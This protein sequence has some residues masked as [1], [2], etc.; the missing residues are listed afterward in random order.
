M[1]SAVGNE[2]APQRVPGS[3]GENANES[4]VGGRQQSLGLRVRGGGY[5]DICTDS[6]AA[7]S[8]PA[9]RGADPRIDELRTVGLPRIW[10]TVAQEIGFEAF[11]R[12]WHVMMRYGHVDDRSRVV[13]PNFSRYTRFQRNQLVRNL[14]ME[15]LDVDE[16]REAVNR[17]T[18][19]MISE[20][21]IRRFATRPK[22]GA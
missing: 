22:I 5:P 8:A 18:G 10:I 13:V 11:M 7:G 9:A 14:A 20:S 1:N 16:I 3:A 4:Q 17:A 21:Q 15:G 19:E 6:I 12:L 2:N